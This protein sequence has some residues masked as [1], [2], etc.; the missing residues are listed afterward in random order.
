MICEAVGDRRRGFLAVA[1]LAG[2]QFGVPFAL[3]LVPELLR[4]PLPEPKGAL[5]FPI[6]Y[7]VALVG[8]L[9][10]LAHLRGRKVIAPAEA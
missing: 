8:A 1:G 4:V 3:A 2:F 9:P 10:P 6:A 7:V 5:L